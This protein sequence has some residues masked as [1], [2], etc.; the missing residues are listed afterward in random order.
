MQHF[1]PIDEGKE[2]SES[3]GN[4]TITLDNCSSNFV[5]TITIIIIPF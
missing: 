1:I 4:Q 3:A 5:V 2:F